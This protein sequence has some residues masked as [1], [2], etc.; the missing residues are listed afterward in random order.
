MINWRQINNEDK[1]MQ[2]FSMANKTY[3][4]QRISYEGEISHKLFDNWLGEIY[5]W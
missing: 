4:L 5:R 2:G 1:K 3:W